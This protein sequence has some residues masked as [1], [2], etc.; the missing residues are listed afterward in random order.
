MNLAEREFNADQYKKLGLGDLEQ[1]YTARITPFMVNSL[2]TAC[3]LLESETDEDEARAKN[4]A[5][6]SLARKLLATYTEHSRREVSLI[7]ALRTRQIKRGSD[8]IIAEIHAL[9]EGH[10]QIRN[11]FEQLNAFSEKCN[12]A[13]SCDALHKLGF[14]HINNIAQDISRIFFL[15]EEYLFPRLPVMLH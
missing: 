6:I 1:L 11:Y 9:K 5:I 4:R 13:E 10:R 3:L 8:K 12:A 2:E 7:A 14:A 15:E